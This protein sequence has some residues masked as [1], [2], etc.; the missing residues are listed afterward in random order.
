MSEPSPER[1]EPAPAPAPIPVYVISFDQLTYLR[2]MIAQLRDLGVI[3]GDIHVVDNHSTLPPLL[4]YLTELER[5]GHHVHRLPRNLGPHAVFNLEAGLELPATFAVTDPD[6]QF[7]ADMP[8][9]FR[10]DLAAVAADAAVWKAGCALEIGSDEE[11]LPGTYF[12]GQTIREWEARFW[13]QPQGEHRF[14]PL[15]RAWIDTT[16][17]VYRRDAPHA[18]FYGAVR[19]AGCYVAR[20]LPWYRE[21]FALPAG[22]GACPPVPARLPDGR[23]LVRPAPCELERYRQGEKG[24]TTAR[25]AATSQDATRYVPI[26]RPEDG[27]TFAIGPRT[28]HAG[29]WSGPFVQGWRAA[30]FAVLRER[31]AARRGPS[32]LV[33]VGASFGKTALWAA[34]RFEHVYAV[35][36][37]VAARAE[38]CENVA[39][40]RF[41]HCVTVVPCALADRDR[42]GL[43]QGQGQADGRPSI[44]LETLCARYAVPLQEGTNLVIN[45]DAGSAWRE[46]L[47]GLLAFAAA[48][49]DVVGAL[50][51]AVDGTRGGE[52]RGAARVVEEAI[53]AA[54]VLRDWAVISDRMTPLSGP[55]AITEDVEGRPEALLC[56]LNPHGA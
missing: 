20:H 8:A 11:L 56:W 35:E 39:V 54:P 25:M 34:L 49:A 17:A 43:D 2:N 51:V 44:T 15:H 18:D 7:H 6:L 28:T 42:Q 10:Q 45:C 52:G 1:P 21:T 33:D 27:Y 48:R 3:P 4:D 9:S 46:L 19:V 50:L 26:A 13:R 22:P 55:A 29:W 36:P 12:E 14:G 5:Q 16:F 47:P 31:S 24:S 40:N 53:A 41:E 37:D 32:R 30:A 23:P 38:L